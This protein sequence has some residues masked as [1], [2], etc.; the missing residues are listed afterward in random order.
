MSYFR[1]NYVD[2]D[3]PL[4]LNDSITELVIPEDLKEINLKLADIRTELND[5]YYTLE[6]DK[7]GVELAK[8]VQ[9][10]KDLDMMSY[11]SEGKKY[12][13][14]MLLYMTGLY[15]LYFDLLLDLQIINDSTT[16]DYWPHKKLYEKL[17]FNE[18]IKK[19][20]GDTITTT[21]DTG[22]RE[23]L[24]ESSIQGNLFDPLS[25][26]LN[27]KVYTT[28]Q[29]AEYLKANTN[30]YGFAHKAWD[31][32]VVEIKDAKANGTGPS[33]GVLHEYLTAR[34]VFP[35]NTHPGDD[36]EERSIKDFMKHLN[37]IT[38][39]YRGKKV[40][41]LATNRLTWN[42]MSCLLGE[43]MLTLYFSEEPIPDTKLIGQIQ[44][45]TLYGIPVDVVDSFLREG[46]SWGKKFAYEGH[47]NTVF[48]K[49]EKGDY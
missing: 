29:Y 7:E 44:K 45:N 42:K 22:A 1:E 5:G 24:E 48:V 17:G 16:V 14:V 25:D 10:V 26:Q 15:N 43:H 47:P 39:F 6:F 34:I 4:V 37:N 12:S 20:D 28:E 32:L 11:F 19:Q 18:L 23:Y 8:A 27:A 33:P 36:T 9:Y 38:D 41:G 2:D 13:Y 31:E 3:T 21:L 49:L 35:S 46:T 40:L 30:K